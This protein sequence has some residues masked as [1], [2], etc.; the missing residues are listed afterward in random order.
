MIREADQMEFMVTTLSCIGD[1]VIVTDL[2]G[3][4]VYFNAQAEKLTGWSDMDSTGRPFGEVFVLIDFLTGNR[5]GNP[6]L[7]ALEYGVAVGLQDHAALITRSGKTRFV[8]A[9]CS[10][11]RNGSGEAAGAVVVFR[12]IDRIKKIEEELRGEKNNLQNV[13]EALPSGILLVGGDAVVKWVNRPLME[14]F[15][16]CEENIV[17]QRFGDGSHCIYSYEKGCGEGE[18]C[19]L[20]E[21]RQSIGM[22]LREGVSR[23]DVILHRA[24][25][26]GA[27]EN[28]FWLRI[29]FIPLATSSGNQ[30]VVAIED[31][32]EQKNYETS[33]ERGR[34]EAE[35][36]NRVK[37]E[38]LANISHE[39]R[40]PLNGM[41]GMLDLMMMSG[42]TEE[43]QEY[44][45]MAKFSAN[46]LLKVI[47]DILD[48]SRIEAGKISFAHI[49][50]DVRAL[51]EE[52][53]KIHA[54]L[55]RKK[56]LQMELLFDEEI[57]PSLIGDPDRLRQILNNLI[58]NAIKFTDQGQI[59]LAVRKKAGAGK[60][61]ELEFRVSDTGIGISAE[62]TDVLF[63]RF[64]QV[65]GSNTRKYGGTGLGLAICKQLVERM[66]GNIW[67]QSE[68]GRGSTFCF[69]VSF[70]PGN[71]PS[72]GSAP[73]T[74]Q[75]LSLFVVRKAKRNPHLVHKGQS[76]VAG[77]APFQSM[78][79]SQRFNRVSLADNGEIVY[80][81]TAQPAG[82]AAPPDLGELR[83]ALRA[84]QAIVQQ[85][86]LPL[87]EEAA[88]RV[89]GAARRA[90]L[91]DLVDLAFKI[92]LAARKCK[93]DQAKQLSLE[94]MDEFNIR[95][96]G[97]T[98]RE[99]TD[100]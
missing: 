55:A 32:T 69:T 30:I 75:P 68:P 9:S 49:P 58:G 90:N 19:R 76:A 8:S 51:A 100:C 60:A 31:V 1:G 61:A 79:A 41:I 26:N 17:G 63:K 87:V 3:K 11:I 28:C 98:K 15:H 74:E 34:E 57:P 56:G 96:R 38:F 84:L 21:I 82:K 71:E 27:D 45:Q 99:N 59:E 22:V 85:D 42:P 16:T 7:P 4:I 72:D 77:A 13:L 37:S 46:S 36:A 23:K 39:V 44:L 95:Y 54:V 40:T 78:G 47:N 70:D 97:G 29:N 73:K 89:K 67:A 35:S 92:E 53:V 10:P 6:I 65:D 43:Q 20:C 24:F 81:A 12:D 83:Q 91:G 80:S 48:F 86:N 52:I 66:G 88:H 94:A 33:L 2:Q 14:L 93:W 64:S 50:F 5:L 18:R 62:K 25:L